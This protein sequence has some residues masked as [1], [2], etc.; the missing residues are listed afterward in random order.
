MCDLT[1]RHNESAVHRVPIEI[2]WKILDNVIYGDNYLFLSTTFSGCDWSEYATWTLVTYEGRFYR[3]SEKQRKV[4]GSVCRS[5]QAFSR[6]RSNR[7]VSINLPRK[8]EQS[9]EVETP[10]QETPPQETPPQETPP[11]RRRISFRSIFSTLFRSK[12]IPHITSKDDLQDDWPQ[13]VNKSRQARRIKVG[14]D[15]WERFGELFEEMGYVA[16]WEIVDVGRHEVMELSRLSLP[17]LR[18][19]RLCVYDDFSTLNL[20]TFLEALSKF[21]N[22]TWFEYEADVL[23][24][25]P[26]PIDEDKSPLLLP[27][28]QVLWFKNRATFEFPFSHLILP[29]LRYLSLQIYELPS[30][31]PLLDLLSCYRQTLRSLTANV[32]KTRGDDPVVHFPPWDEF[33]ELEELVL[34]QQWTAYFQPL[35]TNHPLRRLD[36]NYESTDVIPSLLEGTNM[37]HIILRRAYWRPDGSLGRMYDELMIDVKEVNSILRRGSHRGISFKVAKYGEKPM[38]RG[39]AMAVA[40]ASKKRSRYFS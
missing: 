20:N 32:F 13:I 3:L 10:P 19:L 29:S 21:P 16:D 34:D 39:E 24:G 40:A 22:L 12:S 11:Q 33:P 17:R 5:W 38:S 6:S 26:V 8:H 28:L 2:W 36:A 1:T 15:L 7:Y 27:N 31:I 18:R 4:V 14:F 9:P 30:R 23:R 37:R 35:P 25:Q